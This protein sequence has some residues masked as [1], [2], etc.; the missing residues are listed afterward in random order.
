MSNWYSCGFIFEG[1]VPDSVS[2]P[3][4]LADGVRIERLPDWVKVDEATGLESWSTREHIKEAVAGFVMEFEASALDAG[5]QKAAE[6]IFLAGVAMWLAQP[7]GWSPAHITH[8]GEK[9]RAGSLRQTGECSVLRVAPDQAYD[10]PTPEALAKAA[11]LHAAILALRRD[12]AVWSALRH[13]TIAA[14]EDLWEPRYVMMWV[15]LEALFGPEDAR[16]IT[17]R[18]S[19]RIGL[20]LGK[21][22]QER[23]QLFRDARAGYG[24]RSKV[25][26]GGRLAGLTG[27]R[28]GEL[29]M[30]VEALIRRAVVTLLEDAKLCEIFDGAGREKYLD[31]LAFRF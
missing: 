28:S 13:L 8:F 19:Q 12:G 5:A 29:M 4:E 15:A 22:P 16:E 30:T 6:K 14:P 3:V 1:H 9:G 21:E 31:E 7:T 23:G 25:V 18:M 10:V 27:E 2:L 26:H 20:F 24:M 17:Y 11:R